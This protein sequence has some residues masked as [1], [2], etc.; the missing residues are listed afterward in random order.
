MIN[1][2][3]DLYEAIERNPSNRSFWLSV[4][5][6]KFQYSSG[7]RNLFLYSDK[8]YIISEN[9]WV[10]LGDKFGHKNVQQNTLKG[11]SIG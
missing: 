4:H 3:I 11:L 1:T 10:R 8:P 7:V 6:S 5:T 9:I 2:F